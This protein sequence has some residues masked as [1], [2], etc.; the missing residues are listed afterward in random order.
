MLEGIVGETR[1]ALVLLRDC[2]VSI[3]ETD[4]SGHWLAW[5]A[6]NVVTRSDLFPDSPWNSDHDTPEKRWG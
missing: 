2:S 3:I 4:K 5:G 6:P 1:A